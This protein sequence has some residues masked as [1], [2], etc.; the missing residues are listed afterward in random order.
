MVSARDIE[1]LHFCNPLMIFFKILRSSVKKYVY[2][3]RY[4]QYI[5]FIFCS[6]NRIKLLLVTN[7]LNSI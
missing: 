7:I 2:Y 4:I 5:Y 3:I 1:R 6:I